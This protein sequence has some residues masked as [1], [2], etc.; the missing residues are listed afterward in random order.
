MVVPSKQNSESVTNLVDVMKSQ[1]E[2]KVAIGDVG[3]DDQ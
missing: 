1:R 2:Q 3:G